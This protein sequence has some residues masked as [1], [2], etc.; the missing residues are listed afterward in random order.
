VEKKIK[1]LKYKFKEV[2]GQVIS[3]VSVFFL[4]KFTQYGLN[5][6]LP[7]HFQSVVNIH[8]HVYETVM[9]L[10]LIVPISVVHGE[11]LRRVSSFAVDIFRLV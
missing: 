1:V 6:F 5:H 10:S 3:F 2:C 7:I 8:L 4:I 9:V 11:L